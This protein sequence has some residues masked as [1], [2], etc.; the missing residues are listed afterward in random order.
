MRIT[1][2]TEGGIANF[3]GLQHPVSLSVDELPSAQQ[4]ELRSLIDQCDFF[5]LTVNGSGAPANSVLQIIVTW[6]DPNNPAD[7]SEFDLLVYDSAGNVVGT[8]FSGNSTPRRV[9]L[10][11]PPDGTQFVVQV[12]PFNPQGFSYTATASF[13]PKPAVP[14]VPPPNPQ[15]ARFQTY[16]SPAGLGDNAGEPSIGI[17]Q[18]VYGAIIVSLTLWMPGGVVALWR[19]RRRARLVPQPA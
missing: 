14:P 4:S 10:Q 16:L 8:A 19:R 11:I 12:V 13:V 18:V 1:V 2:S 17:D 15:A 5:N 9:T 7:Q 6:P 3:P